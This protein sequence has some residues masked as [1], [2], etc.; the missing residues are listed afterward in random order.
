MGAGKEEGF[1]GT[2]IQD[3]WTKPRGVGSGVGGGNA[4]G[5][6]EWWGEWRQLDLSNNKKNKNKIL[7][8]RADAAVSKLGVDANTSTHFLQRNLY[9]TFKSRDFKKLLTYGAHS[10]SKKWSQRSHQTS[11]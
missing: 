9:V 4:W 7:R 10:T 6:G 1:S 11:E 8:L 2:S 3:T 5:G